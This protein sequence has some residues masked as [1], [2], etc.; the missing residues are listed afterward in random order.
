MSKQKDKKDIS[1]MNSIKSFFLI[2]IGVVVWLFM[3]LANIV[4]F[5]LSFIVIPI[6]AIF[7]LLFVVPFVYINTR[8]PL[9]DDLREIDINSIEIKVRREIE[10][11]I[12]IYELMGFEPLSILES[13]V[14]DKSKIYLQVMINHELGVSLALFYGVFKDKYSKYKEIELEYL[15]FEFENLNKELI[16]VTNNRR[17]K[18]P[19]PKGIHQYFID[20]EY[21]DSFQELILDISQKGMINK[22]SKSLARLQDDVLKST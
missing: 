22:N 6:I 19:S 20:L 11:K 13:Q 2:F 3:I 4:F 5:I 7:Q 12:F 21:D 1:K 8:Q 17:N 10:K 18:L 16:Q 15:S 14:D 9:E